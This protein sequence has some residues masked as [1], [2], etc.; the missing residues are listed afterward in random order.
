MIDARR[1]IGVGVLCSLTAC[2]APKTS[3]PGTSD[4]P[5]RGMLTLRRSVVLEQP[6]SA[7]I[8]QV[9][10][11]AFAP[12]G[13]ILVADRVQVNAKLYDSTGHLLRVI[14]RRGHGPGEFQFPR[15]AQFTP[16]KR[17][18][19]A[20]TRGGIQ[21]FSMS[22][23]VRRTI[24]PTGL[25]FYLGIRVLAGGD[26]LILGGNGR[27]FILVRYDSAGGHPR[28]LF[29]RERVPVADHPDSP[30]WM[31]LSLYLFGADADTA[32]VIGSLSD[33]IWKVN[34]N[35]GTVSMS[36]MRFDGFDR[37][38]LPADP[39]QDESD[40]WAKAFYRAYRPLGGDGLVVI[41]FA[42]GYPNNSDGQA[43]LIRSPQGKW[44]AVTDTP[45]IMAVT[46]SD[47]VEAQV[48]DSGAVR[49]NFYRAVAASV[50]QP[51]DGF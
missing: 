43:V 8:G 13:R 45:M 5:L 44:L 36:L 11:L 24:T 39:P 6:D 4:N 9:N 10:A 12:D 2:S 46:D 30:L 33:T 21:E 27:K 25:T 42:K 31:R 47:L 28:E 23:D 16:G 19:V 29:Q 34:V 32:F 48:S 22:G 7:L 17:I 38:K 40:D 50:A 51:A 49:I 37:P 26:F 35:T 20:D 41:P 18:M 15:Y 3:R 14:G 1:A